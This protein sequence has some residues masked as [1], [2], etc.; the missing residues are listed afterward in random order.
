MTVV[1]R[2]F[3]VILLLMGLGIFGAVLE[4]FSYWRHHIPGGFVTML[5]C[6]IGMGAAVFICLEGYSESEA[7]YASIITGKLYVCCLYRLLSLAGKSQLV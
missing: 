3:L 4:V 7:I 1:G 6:I 2:I 5:S